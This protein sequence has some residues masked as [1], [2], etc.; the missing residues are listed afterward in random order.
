MALTTITNKLPG[1]TVRSGAQHAVRRILGLASKVNPLW[2]A[3]L[4]L[5]A[6]STPLRRRKLDGDPLP[7]K[8]RIRPTWINGR[9]VTLYQYGKS[10]RKV[11]LVHGWEGAACDFGDYF[12][13]LVQ[14]GYEVCAVDLPGHGLSSGSHLNV[15]E[16]AKI[17]QSL[18]IMHGPYSAIIGHSF[19]AFSAG[20]AIS[21]FSELSGMPFVSIGSPNT[22]QSVLS[23]FSEVAGL[24][25][26]QSNYMICKIEKKFGIKI[27]DFKQSS[28]LARHNG[29]TLVVH[30]ELD[31]QVPIHEVEEMQREATN[32][33][34]L[35]TA[36]LGHNR[37]LR[38][39]KT[40]DSII[41]YIDGWRDSREDFEMA[42]KFGII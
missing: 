20:H 10:S 4:G 41:A 37:I 2:A 38:D 22:L 15:S 31:K 14:A 3:D 8:T 12:E 34:Y 25:N 30:D 5:L 33:D 35:V 26:L 40:I 28:F 17:V 42:F 39:K 18:E 21:Q 32:V 9:E 23:S 13:P 27:R 1:T 19:G 24:T 7:V 16:V 11:L 29:P 36:G 6:F